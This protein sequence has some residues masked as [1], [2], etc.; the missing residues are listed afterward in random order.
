MASMPLMAPRSSTACQTEAIKRGRYPALPAGRTL[1]HA[2]SI[3]G[4]PGP[5]LSQASDVRLAAIQAGAKA[6][7]LESWSRRAA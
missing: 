3:S 7:S 6:A 5:S 4:K 2:A 1:N